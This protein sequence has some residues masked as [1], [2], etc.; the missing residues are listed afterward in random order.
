M[1]RVLVTGGSGLIGRPAVLALARAGWEVHA[2]ARQPRTTVERVRWHALDLLAPGAGRRLVDDVRPSHLLHLAWCTDSPGHLWSSANERWREA[3]SELV[4]AFAS[5]GGRR[6]VLAGSCVEYDWSRER[7][8][9]SE[10]ET[11][12]IPSYEY[13]RAKDELRRE[14]E[15]LGEA[16]RVSVGWGRIFFIY[17]V[18][19]RPS[20]LVSGLSRSLLAGEP[21]P[22]ADGTRVRDFLFSTDAS[23]A[24]VALLSSDVRGSVNIAS[25]AAVSIREVAELLA[26]EAGRPDL[27]RIEDSPARSQEPRR[28]VADVRRLREEVGWEPAVS[29]RDGLRR[30]LAWWRARADARGGL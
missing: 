13:G 5:A 12:I 4:H 18:G 7:E 10:T 1:K 27:L 17:G 26:A 16:A 11:P 25:G 21:I 20:R 8:R 29:L 2:V 28:L 19:D 14:A 30:T 22:V 6:A 24:L 15:E 23:E 9:L 3:G